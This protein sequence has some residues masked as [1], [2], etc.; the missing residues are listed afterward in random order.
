MSS[1]LNITRYKTQD[2]L[3]ILATVGCNKPVDRI[4]YMIKPKKFGY[5]NVSYR[6]AWVDRAG[7]RVEVAL[8]RPDKLGD[9]ALD[10][11]ANADDA[12]AHQRLVDDLLFTA[13]KAFNYQNPDDKKLAIFAAKNHT[14]ELLEEVSGD[15][16]ALSAYKNLSTKVSCRTKTLQTDKAQIKRAQSILKRLEPTISGQEKELERLKGQLASKK[17]DLK[18]KGLI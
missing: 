9:N 4:R 6:W 8:L 5:G 16:K 11:I 7:D 18:A 10:F 17:A 3:D 14:I 13:Y 1:T 2:V 15:A 12:V